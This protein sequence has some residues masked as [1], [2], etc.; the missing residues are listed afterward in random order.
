MNFIGTVQ[1]ENSDGKSWYSSSTFI[2]E[3]LATESFRIYRTESFTYKFF[4]SCET[5][6]FGWKIMI[7]A[8]SLSQILFSTRNQWKTKGFPYEFFQLW[9]TSKFR[10][11]LLIPSPLFYL[12]VFWLPKALGNTAQKGSSTKLFNLARQNK[13]AGKSLFPRTLLSLTF[14][15]TRNHWNTKWFPFESFGHCATSKFR[16]K[17]LVLFLFFYL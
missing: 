14:F 7:P 15:D 16:Q 17:I 11:K 9:T 13:S 2:Y 4:Q 12:Q 1:K 8:H 5:K 3:F 6:H 10:R